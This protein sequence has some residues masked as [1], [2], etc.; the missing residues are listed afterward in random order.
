MWNDTDTPLADLV[1]FRT[2]GTWLHGDPRGSVNRFRNTFGTRRLP[3]EESWI[4]K[5][6]QRLKRE[7]VILDARQRKSVEKAIR[8][9]CVKRGWILLA[10]NV[11]T[12]HVHIVVSIGEG[13]ASSALNAFKANA[14]RTMRQAGCW[15]S[16]ST[17]WVDKGSQRY[18]WTK[19]GVERAVD[20]VLYGQGSD[21]PDFDQP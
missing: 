11:R 2:Y 17:P 16:A 5:N 12:N 8:E 20:Y 13:K 14:T 10:V 15:D 4:D 21:L 18:L 9:T 19:R 3:P 7:V 1:T 6:T